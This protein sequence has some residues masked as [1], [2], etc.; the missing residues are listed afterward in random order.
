MREYK[1][2][3][4]SRPPLF[5]HL[6]LWL[7]L[8]FVVTAGVWAHY[9]TID[10]V[11]RGSGKVIP[12]SH[13]QIVQNLEGGIISKIFIKE[14][15]IVKRNQI[16]LQIDDTRFASSYRESQVTSLA[17][18]A[19]IARLTA[20]AQEKIF[21]LPRRLTTAQRQLFINQH[22]LA[23]S[24]Q[25]EL[26]ANIEIIKQQKKQKLHEINE[27]KSRQRQLQHSYDLA[28]R[29][30][31]I[32]EPLVKKGVMSEVELLRLQREVSTIKA[33]LEST[34]LNIPRARAAIT[35]TERKIEELKVSFRTRSLAELNEIKA[36]LSRISESKR[37]L[38]DRVTRTAVRSPVPG[39]IKQ[40]KVTT[41][42]GV[43]QPGM[44]LVEIVPLN[45]TLLIEAQIRPSDIA[46]LYPGQTAMVKLTAYDF[47]IFGGLKASL[48]HISA[49]T[50]SNERNEPFFKIRL[51]TERNYLGT[52]KK[53]LPIIA[54]MTVSVDIL[55]GKKSLLDYLLK[56]IKKAQE[57]ALRER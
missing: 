12:S 3:L 25:Q 22:A 51:R 29:E 31:K 28:Q 7:T 39:I 14:G 49:D 18:E 56:P 1:Y 36:E 55:T 13:V 48:E 20:E 32:T 21:Y 37:A 52:K 9:S 35:E 53:P 8:L 46:F 30:L 6:I 17:M 24:R 11:T 34:R 26:Q 41:I 43:V 54:G 27:L 10:E 57:Q 33:E 50:I 19:K 4:N 23:Q 42:G 38:E 15:D 44:D 5:S 2:L 45:D 16:L 47:S 40:L